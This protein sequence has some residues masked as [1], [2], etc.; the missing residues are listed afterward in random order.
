[1]LACDD[2]QGLDTLMIAPRTVAALATVLLLVAGCASA[3]TPP[4]T[5]AGPSLVP[6]APAASVASSGPATPL[7]AASTPSAPPASASPIAASAPAAPPASASPTA[8][9]GSPSPTSIP[10][11][12]G[13]A[14]RIVVGSLGIDLPVVTL[15]ASGV[16]YCGVAMRW[17]YRGFVE[18]GQVGSVYLLAHARAGM[19]LP[20]L[21]AS[22][23]NGGRSLV[24]RKVLLYTSADW[25]FSYDITRVRRHV[26]SAG[27][28]RLSTPLAARDPELWMQTSEGAT[29]ASPLLQVAAVLVAAR[30][31]SHAASHPTPRPMVCG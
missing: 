18:P 30:P 27:V 14:T 17:P 26:P 28:S 7:T 1:L 23:R 21:D 4:T 9:A 13:T 5:I 22:L 11:V 2:R 19:F 29:T 20:L 31:A 12:S 24:G 3:P 10:D 6:T 16:H 8:L 25:V 15:P